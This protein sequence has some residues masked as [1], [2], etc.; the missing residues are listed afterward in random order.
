MP[1]PGIPIMFQPPGSMIPI[2]MPPTMMNFPMNNNILNQMPQTI[3][4]YMGYNQMDEEEDDDEPDP[5][6]DD[7]STDLNTINPFV[8]MENTA[9]IVKKNLVE[10]KWFL[11]RGDKILGIY[12]S[13][14]L[15]YF[16]TSQIQ[17]GN[18]FEDMSINDHTTD[19]HFKPSILYDTLKKYVPKLKKRYIKKVMEQSNEM[20]K[21]MQQQQIMQMNNQ[22]NQMKLLQMNQLAMMQMNNKNNNNIQEGSN[23]NQ[24][25]NIHGHNHHNNYNNNYNNYNKHYNNNNHGY[26]NM[27][28]NQYQGGNHYNNYKKSY[29]KYN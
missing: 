6:L 19:M 2:N 9:L 12:N 5:I 28:Y 7:D 18:K 10:Q 27:N 17:K 21:K 26:N 1:N 24:N 29:G 15:L 11:M 8:L 13:E 16:L 3:Q 23:N 4:P 25:N 20:M 22:L 14:Q